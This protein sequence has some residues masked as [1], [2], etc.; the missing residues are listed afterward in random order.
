MT[1][2]THSKSRQQSQLLE[3]AITRIAEQVTQAVGADSE[4]RLTSD[5]DHPVVQQLCTALNRLMETLGVAAAQSKQV[6][7]HDALTDLP[8][9]ILLGDRFAQ[10][11]A[12]A[13]RYHRRV[14]LLMVDFDVQSGAGE[15]LGHQAGAE[16]LQE[17]SRRLERSV[18]ACDTVARLGGNT[19]VVLL[20]EIA[21]F[22]MTWTVAHRIRDSLAHPYATAADELSVTP[23]IGICAYP[24]DGDSLEG[25]LKKSEMALGIAR[26]RE[27]RIHATFTHGSVAE[28][29]ERALLS[30]ALSHAVA[31][32]ELVLYYQPIAHVASGKTVGFEALLRWQHPSLGQIPP[33]R[34]VQLAEETGLIVSI[35]EWAV[36]TAARQIQAW[37]A[38][39]LP[40]LTVAINLSAQQLFAPDLVEM[41]QRQLTAAE[42][43]CS[44][45]EIEV[46]ESSVLQNAERAKATMSRLREMGIGIV[47]DDFSA[48]YTSLRRLGQMPIDAIKIDRFLVRNIIEDPDKAAVVMGISALAR[49]LGLRV[50]AEGVETEA[51]LQALRGS[52]G[53]TSQGL[54]CDFAQGFLFGKPAGADKVT[55][56]LRAG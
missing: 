49:R 17:V 38:L 33:L 25:L 15:P 21:A 9:L 40:E 52:M 37:R 7:T 10:T 47:V 18:R 6:A 12:R 56:A 54:C 46:T 3:A 24:E 20:D 19:F 27:H 42:V 36:A 30:S 29:S 28:D 4:V 26:Q 34:F 35:G 44:A 53:P 45:M 2:P 14:G 48:G 32:N 22:E 11:M 16:L 55:E 5:L 41:F 13:R 39:G 23:S 50:I 8:N 51:Q 31:R 1:A 43:P